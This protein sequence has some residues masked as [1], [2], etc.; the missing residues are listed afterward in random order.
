MVGMSASKSVCRSIV[1]NHATVRDRADMPT[2]VRLC[3]ERGIETV[4]I[5][6]DEIERVGEATALAALR[7]HGI[8]VSGYNRIGPFT[9]EGLARAPFELE[10]AAR[11]G[12]DHVFLFTGGLAETE[13]DLFAAR[14]RAEDRIAQL[15]EMARR[16]GIKLAIEPLHPMLV[17]DRTVIA[18]LSHANKL[19]EALGSGIGVVVDV[20]HVWWDERLEAE[21]LRAGQAG[22]LFGFHVNDWLVPTRHLLTDR[23]M[24]GDGIIH[25]ASIDRM[26]RQAGFEGPVE[27]ELFSTDW[28]ARDPAEVLD[29]ALSR[30]QRIFRSN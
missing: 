29:I 10:R 21:I 3:A 4:S 14:K 24:M 27:V 7:T 30:C 11:F 20:Y 6:G 15:L 2:F 23:G 17:G 5:W 8:A 9:D 18:S 25:L 19:C 12:A 1:I 13:H 28:W 16:V 22:R 26:M